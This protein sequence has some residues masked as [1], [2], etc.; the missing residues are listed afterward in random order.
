M[1]NG[2]CLGVLTLVGVD[3]PSFFCRFAATEMFAEVAPIFAAEREAARSK[4][5]NAWHKRF[6]EIRDL[7]L[8]LEPIGRSRPIGFYVFYVDGERA[9]FR[10]RFERKR[11]ALDAK[12][13]VDVT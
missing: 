1:R 11:C 3:Q 5:E 13:R 9:W 2:N 12:V 6:H 8:S 7:G 4:D 10:P